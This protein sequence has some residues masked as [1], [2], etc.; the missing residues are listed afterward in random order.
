MPDAFNDPA[1]IAMWRRIDGRLTTSGQ[2]TEAQLAEIKALGVVEIVNIG[3]HTHEKALPD[4]RASVAALG[5]RYT[6]IPVDFANP[7][8]TD[9]D[10]FR[11]AMKASADQMIHVHCIANMR[12]SAFLYR[13][14]RDQGVMAEDEA[15]ALMDQLW[16][17]GGVWA[18]FLGDEAAVALDHRYAGHHY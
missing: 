6:Y 15:R 8:E 4:E 16:R 9:F 7:T 2:P 12:V 14:H 18:A 17:P 3:P 5:M 13:Y 10:R 1:D 11:A